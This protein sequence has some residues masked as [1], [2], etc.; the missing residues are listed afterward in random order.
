[1]AYMSHFDQFDMGIEFPPYEDPP[2]PYTPHKPQDIPLGEAPPPYQA[3]P[4]HNNNNGEVGTENGSIMN[5]GRPL[6]GS[7][8]GINGHPWC[9]DGVAL[10]GLTAGRE[11]SCSPSSISNVSTPSTAPVSPSGGPVVIAFASFRR[12]QA[13]VR[14]ENDSPRTSLVHERS[15]PDH[16][17]Q[18]PLHGDACM[19]KSGSVEIKLG[20]CNPRNSYSQ[21]ETCRKTVAGAAAADEDMKGGDDGDESQDDEVHFLPV[22]GASAKG[23]GDINLSW[24]RGIRPQRIGVRCQNGMTG[25]VA[26]T[27]GSSAGNSPDTGQPDVPGRAVPSHTYQPSLS[28]QPSTA[29]DS[30]SPHSDSDPSHPVIGTRR[31]PVAT[32]GPLCNID[33]PRNQQLDSSRS[34]PLELPNF[35]PEMGRSASMTSQFS[36]CSETGEKRP[37]HGLPMALA[38]DAQY[39]DSLF[40]FSGPEHPDMVSPGHASGASGP[41]TPGSSEV[42]PYPLPIAD[43]GAATTYNQRPRPRLCYVDMNCNALGA[44]PSE[45]AAAGPVPADDAGYLDSRSKPM[46]NGQKLHCNGNDT[47]VSE[48]KQATQRKSKEKTKEKTGVYSKGKSDSASSYKQF[49]FMDNQRGNREKSGSPSQEGTRQQTR[50][51]YQE[52]K[53]DIS[54]EKRDSSR[55]KKQEKNKDNHQERRSKS[56]ERTTSRESSKERARSNSKTRQSR[57]RSAERTQINGQTDEHNNGYTNGHTNNHTNGYTKDSNHDVQENITNYITAHSDGMQPGSSRARK[58]KEGRPL[59][60]DSAQPLASLEHKNKRRPV[61]ARYIPEQAQLVSAILTSGRSDNLAS[62]S[63][64]KYPAKSRSKENRN[65]IPL[66]NHSR[67]VVDR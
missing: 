45:A 52:K 16:P 61:S 32:W 48:Q 54:K 7:M 29:S 43:T 67:S 15:A 13:V 66:I 64:Y 30:S 5:G 18:D 14:M 25:S 39:P 57:N 40:K 46:T 44:V 26:S 2:P 33:R 59:E 51:S 63:D 21:E 28:R 47:N 8:R 60:Q 35:L 17:F 9:R 23:L 38:N 56:K 37:R 42:P 19:R 24:N 4:P 50:D 11:R 55:E 6:Q 41:S 10:P 36:V 1:M 31:S 62:T 20:S 3:N 65:S 27:P 12:N 22:T 34:N 58:A 49:G 53:R